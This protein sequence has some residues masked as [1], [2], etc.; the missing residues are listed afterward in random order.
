M[1]FIE[2]IEHK[3]ARMAW[4]LV[5]DIPANE[6]DGYASLVNS[7]PVMIITNGLGQTLAFLISKKKEIKYRLIYEHLNNWLSNNIIWTQ[8]EDVTDDL[9]DR[10]IHENSQV[11]R[12]ATEEALAFIA[13]VKRFATAL[14]KEVSQ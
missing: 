12:M 4:S 14:S 7:I 13:W 9:I 3:R 6:I 10:V 11:Y 1:T 8:S 2:N 5:N